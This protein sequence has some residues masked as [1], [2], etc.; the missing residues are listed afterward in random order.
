MLDCEI[1]N[2]LAKCKLIFFSELLKN[3]PDK[4]GLLSIGAGVMNLFKSGEYLSTARHFLPKLS[5]KVVYNQSSFIGVL[6]NI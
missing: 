1:S 6:G 5:N 3:V 4:I 2:V